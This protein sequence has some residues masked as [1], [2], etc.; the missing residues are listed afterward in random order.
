[1]F[2]AHNRDIENRVKA[3]L[4]EAQSIAQ[5]TTVLFN[6]LNVQTALRADGGTTI[7]Q[8]NEF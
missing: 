8:S 7:S 1:M 5:M 3:M 6:N 4:S 2:R